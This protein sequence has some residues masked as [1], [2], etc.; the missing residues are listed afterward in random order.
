[1]ARAISVR[2]PARYLAVV[3]KP[4]RQTQLRAVV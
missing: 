1:M 3:N 2:R 4:A